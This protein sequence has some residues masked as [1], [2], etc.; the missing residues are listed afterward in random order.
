MMKLLHL[1]RILF[2]I[3]FANKIAVPVK[4]PVVYTQSVS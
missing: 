4:L 1:L 3:T 2:D